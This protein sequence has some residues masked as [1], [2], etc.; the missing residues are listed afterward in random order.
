MIFHSSRLTYRYPR[1]ENSA[2]LADALCGLEVQR[3]MSPSVPLPVDPAAIVGRV[4]GGHSAPFTGAGNAYE[5]AIFEDAGSSEPI[6]IVGLYSIDFAHSVAE[7][8]VS[9]V[10][11]DA[12]GRGFGLEAHRRWVEYAFHDLGLERLTGTAKATNDRAIAIAERLGMTAEGRLRSHRFVE[13]CRIDV[14]VFG[15][16]RD[17]WIE[18]QQVADAS[19]CALESDALS[20]AIERCEVDTGTL[21]AKHD[22]FGGH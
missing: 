12:Q 18:L 19:D 14:I 15:I 4:G 3:L 17:E 10:R 11:G 9:V 8:G 5:L 16:L 22:S 7:L 6:G 13:G 20:V 2:S 21:V 1:P